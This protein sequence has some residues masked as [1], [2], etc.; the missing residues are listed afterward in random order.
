MKK[1]KM[2]VT[3]QAQMPRE[4]AAAAKASAPRNTPRK[5]SEN[6]TFRGVPHDGRLQIRGKSRGKGGMGWTG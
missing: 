1:S 3:R 4:G 6:Y 2:A 5:P